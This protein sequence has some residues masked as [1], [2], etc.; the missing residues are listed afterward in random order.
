MSELA[1]MHRKVKQKHR[2]L[3]LVIVRLSLTYEQ[4]IPGTDQKSNRHLF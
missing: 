2:G 1:C 4:Q 3:E